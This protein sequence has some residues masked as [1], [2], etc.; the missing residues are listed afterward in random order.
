MMFNMGTPIMS[1]T[2][3]DALKMKLLEQG[4]QIAVKVR[5]R[6]T[7][8]AFICFVP[9]ELRACYLRC[10]RDARGRSQTWAIPLIL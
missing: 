6:V 7:S 10:V 4:S 8:H 3:F 5:S 2:E 1:D 9:Q